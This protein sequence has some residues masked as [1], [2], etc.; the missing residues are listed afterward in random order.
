MS[1]TIDSQI[2]RR[3]FKT[4][5]VRFSVS[6]RCVQPQISIIDYLKI[7]YMYLDIH[8]IESVFGSTVF[9]SRLYGGR[10]FHPERSLSDSHI[11]E[12]EE[13]GIGL[14]L[15]LTNHYFNEDAYNRSRELLKRHHKND[16]SVIC[17]ND[18]LAGRIKKDF[19]GYTLKASI[20]K[21]ID[22]IEKVEQY[23]ELYD[24]IVL[25]MDKNDDDAFLQ[26]I[27]EKERIILFGNANCAY[28]CP[29][30]TC[31]L[32]ISQ[33]EAGKP[34]TAACSRKKTPRL[35]MGNVYFDIKK[36]KEMGFSHF[37]L[38]PLSPGAANNALRYINRMRNQ[39][40]GGRNA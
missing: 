6:S 4:T 36:F 24:C 40:D 39:E 31:Y 28:T 13:R 35:E 5:G 38:V 23:L 9:P 25:P 20:V 19:P 1:N 8:Q 27:K 14:S 32:M 22:T 2:F 18:E 7:F 16:N 12:L 11:R 34:V 15:T 17:V 3:V 29:A 10:P 21:Q 33:R 30:R 26:G 37:K